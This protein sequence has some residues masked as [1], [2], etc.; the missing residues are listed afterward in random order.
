MTG[1]II[2]PPHVN[3]VYKPQINESIFEFSPRWPLPLYLTKG[4]MTKSR[5]S[6]KTTFLT[7]HGQS[8]FSKYY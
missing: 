6:G 5:C 1:C 3:I 8:Y 7:N 4:E 2:I